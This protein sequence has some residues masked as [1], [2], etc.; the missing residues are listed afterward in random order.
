MLGPVHLSSTSTTNA[1]SSVNVDTLSFDRMV[2]WAFAG[3][4]FNRHGGSELVKILGP[5]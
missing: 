4:N 3:S 5:A 1:S 2:A